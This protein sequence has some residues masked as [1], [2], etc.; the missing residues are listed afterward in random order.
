[1]SILQWGF[2]LLAIAAAIAELHFGTIYLAG[3]ALAALIASASGFWL[4]GG[5]EVLAFA[6]ASVC[7]LIAVPLLRRRLSRRPAPD[8]D[9]GETVVFLEAGR[10]PGEAVVRYRGARWEADVDPS[11]PI[12]AGGAGTITARHGNRLAV[13]PLPND[14]NTPPA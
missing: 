6:G 3:V 1:M 11:V 2:L 13:T 8:L 4:G 9:A 5:G 14:N 10:C 12:A 7:A